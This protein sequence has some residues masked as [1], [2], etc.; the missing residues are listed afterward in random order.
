MPLVPNTLLSASVTT[1]VALFYYYT[2]VKVSTLR[3]KYKIEAPACSGQ[4]EFERA[5]RVQMNTLEQMAILLPLMWVATLYPILWTWMT[6]LL[7]VIWVISRIIYLRAYMAGPEK[8]LTGWIIGAF[9]NLALL[10][11][12]ISGLT[13]AWRAVNP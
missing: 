1:L 8:R 4:V 13:I 11:L 2:A 3:L 9:C 10:I 6:P 12:A 5:Y 7:G